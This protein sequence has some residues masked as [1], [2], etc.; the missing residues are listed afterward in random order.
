MEGQDLSKK[1]FGAKGGLPSRAKGY[2]PTVLGFS[3]RDAFL[4]GV[5]PSEDIKTDIEQTIRDIQGVRQAGLKNELT[6][7]VAT[8][9][10]ASTLQDPELAVAVEGGK[11]TLSGL[12]P[13]ATKSDIVAAAEQLYGSTNIVDNLQTSDDVADPGWLTG[14]LGILPQIK[15]ELSSGTLT[16]TTGELTLEGTALSEQ[17]KSGLGLAADNATDLS[18]TNNITVAAPVLKPAAL[19]VLLKEGK[20][21][22]AGTVPEATIAPAVEAATQA[23]GAENVVNN[24]V[25][26]DVE[27]P[28]W[29]PG[30]LGALP[31]LSKQSADLGLNVTDKT[32]TLTGKVDSPEKLESVAKAVQDAVGTTVMVE[33]KLELFTAQTPSSVRIKVAQDAVQLSGA[34][35]QIAADRLLELSENVSPTGSVVNQLSVSQDLLTPEW[36]PKALELVPQYA[37]D[38]GEAELNIQD[39]TIT[40]VGSVPTEEQKT[41]V[42]STMREAVGEEPTIANQLRVVPVLVEPSLS[43][44]AQ[45]DKIQFSGTVSQDIASKVSEVVAQTPNVENT[46]SVAENI[47]SPSYLPQ[48]LEAVPAYIQEV[49]RAEISLQDNKLTLLGVVSTQEKKDEIAA[50]LT[51]AAGSTVQVVNNLEVIPS[52]PAQLQVKVVDGVAQ[53][54]GNVPNTLA[55]D[56]LEAV[57]SSPETTSVENQVQA[58]FNVDVPTWLPSVV[59]VLPKVTADVKDA[60][61]NIVADTIT[62]AGTVKSEA[63]KT[64][65]ATQVGTAAGPEVKVVNNLIVEPPVPVQLRVKVSDG[66]VEVEGNVP[67]EIA[68]EAIKDVERLPGIED[69]VVAD[70]I[71]NNIASNPEVEVPAWLPKVV[72]ILPTATAEVKNADVAI[73]GDTVTLGGTVFSEEEKTSVATQ[74]IEAAGPD[75]AVVNNLVVAPPEAVELRITE[76]GN[77]I[78]VQGN[79]EDAVLQATQTLE[80]PADQVSSEVQATPDVQ[81]PTWLPSLVNILPEV[82]AEVEDAEVLIADNTITL[83]GTVASEEEKT[84]L[85]T[86]VSEAAGSEVEV[87]NNLQVEIPE[88]ETAQA[89]EQ[90]EPEVEEPVVEEIPVETEP[91][92]TQPAVEEPQVIEEEPVQVPE[93]EEPQAEAA[94]VVVEEP[95]EVEPVVVE[96][97]I[98]V[99][100]T[101]VTPAEVEA[102]PE[103][104]IPNPNVRIDIAGPEVRLT[105]SVPSAASQDAADNGFENKTVINALEP[106]DVI[107]AS[108]LP[109]LYDLAPRVA[110]D[111]NRVSMVLEDKVL[112]LQGVTLSAEQRDTIGSYVSEA[113][114]PEIT[115]INRL[116]VETKIPFVEDGK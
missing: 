4:R 83:T 68:A 32:L 75:V 9:E 12:V 78:N 2:D 60:D 49:K 72:D 31:A 52:V 85:A 107:D 110:N 45:E 55:A 116:T 16:A 73:L 29:A 103:A 92:Q 5:V 54:E 26:S 7:D 67:S 105:G 3:G 82:T 70:N 6:V 37:K 11:V 57:D 108:W 10:P 98:V 87:I 34:L 66:K 69:E 97:P 91:V 112:T 38:V 24:L 109:K 101:P 21:T 46:L 106:S 89:E 42:E 102:T 30:L 23:V 8:A 35:S 88:P 36:L 115:V 86:R 104:V 50:N 96:E 51:Q 13:L 80:A 64:D 93:A 65:I 44:K 47:A 76:T 111:I 100:T 90:P 43:I 39:K 77:D 62:L 25:A 18:I 61:V 33:N 99:E 48:V 22:L 58:A 84:A 74:V 17:I 56:V 14:V 27:V 95:V 20:A 81:T 1:I 41:T 53:I 113:M 59:N 63:Q 28:V 15:N 79:T 114:Q 40:L 94:P 71:E 19:N